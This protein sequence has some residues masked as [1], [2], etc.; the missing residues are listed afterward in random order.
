M[1]IAN[2]YTIGE[3]SEAESNKHAVGLFEILRISKMPKIAKQF[4]SILTDSPPSF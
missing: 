3:K 4:L 1:S 2:E